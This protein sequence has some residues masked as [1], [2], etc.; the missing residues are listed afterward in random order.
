MG[1]RRGRGC[2][3]PSVPMRSALIRSSASIL[4]ASRRIWSTFPTFWAPDARGN[5]MLGSLPLRTR[6]PSLRRLLLERR[7]QNRQKDAMDY[8]LELV[9][10][11]VADVDRAR[12]FYAEKVGFEVDLTACLVRARAGPPAF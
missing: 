7:R 3:A 2:Y 1:I 10:L 8:R 12:A 11:P 9:P 4:G 5:T 6:L